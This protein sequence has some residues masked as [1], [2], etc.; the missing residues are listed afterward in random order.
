MNDSL[1]TWLREHCSDIRGD[2]AA[3]RIEQL[4]AKVAELEEEI[5]R[6]RVDNIAFA[7]NLKGKSATTGAT[8]EHICTQLAAAQDQVAAMEERLERQRSYFDAHQNILMDEIET[9]EQRVAEAERDAERWRFASTSRNFGITNWC[10]FGQ[11]TSY[12]SSA[13]ELI[14]SAMQSAPANGA[15]S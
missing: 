14:D 15:S 6:L 4:Q 1:I 12:G 2:V 13:E 10:E 8:Y 9:A 11:R 3:D 5:E 7:R